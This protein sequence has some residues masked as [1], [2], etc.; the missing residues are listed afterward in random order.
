MTSTTTTEKLAE[1]V[2]AALKLA[3]GPTQTVDGTELVP[4]ALVG[5]GFGAGD[6]GNENVPEAY[7][8]GGGGGGYAIPVGAYIG[9]PDGLRFRP[10]LIAV[11]AVSIPLVWVAGKAFARI[12]KA[13][14]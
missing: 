6:G 1:A 3:Y 5:Y 7:G 9:G 10:N 14:R 12:L 4:V 2:P 11:I 8:S 13:A